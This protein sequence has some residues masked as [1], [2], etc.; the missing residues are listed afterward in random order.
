MGI[1]LLV[2]FVGIEV[3]KMADLLKSG[4]SML[5]ETCPQCGTPLFRKGTET[6]CAK[7]NRPVV[8]IRNADDETRLKTDQILDGTEQT[9]LSKIQEVNI[10]LRTETDPSRLLNY[11]NALKTWLETIDK[12]RQLK[13][14]D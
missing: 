13:A 5:Q 2:R 1:P 8:I 12:I 6:F 11:G 7:C 4:A 10:A 9:L 14:R 3:K